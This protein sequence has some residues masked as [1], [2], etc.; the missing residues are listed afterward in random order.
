M[1]EGDHQAPVLD[2]DEGDAVAET[3]R[4]HLQ[5]SPVAAMPGEGA[6]GMKRRER[7]EQRACGFHGAIIA[8]CLLAA[9]LAG[10]GYKTDPVYTPPVDH[11]ATQMPADGGR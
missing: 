10:C 1:G 3:R 2:G 4:K 8:S 11:N 9:V 7:S 5:K 6:K